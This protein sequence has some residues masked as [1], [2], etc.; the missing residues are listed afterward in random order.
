MAP[1]VCQSRYSLFIV[2]RDLSKKLILKAEKMGVKVICV[3]VDA[4]VL[5][6]REKDMRLKFVH[7]ASHIQQ[8]S[9]V[10]REKGVSQAL[11]S[12]IDSSLSWD[13]IKWFR[14][15]TKLP[16]VLKG[17][18]IAEDALKAAYYGLDGIIISNHGGRQL[19]AVPSGIEMLEDICNALSEQGLSGRLE[20]M[21]D[22]GFRRGTDIFKALALG[23]KAVGLG[24][25]FLWAMSSYG[26]E[27]VEKA[28][29]LLAEE[30][31]TTMRLAGTP[32]IREITH[33]HVKRRNT[34]SKL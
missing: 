10:Y 29:E 23:A 2:D 20:I 13:D 16:L 5:G 4:P 26:Q 11:S 33:H 8:K 12:F 21:V 34:G 25:P 15:I 7:A 32:T 31:E 22:G 18:H 9:D 24:R 19:D 17:V 28:I 27:G 1:V 14:S 6:R 30:L 3:T